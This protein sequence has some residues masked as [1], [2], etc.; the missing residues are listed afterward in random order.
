MQ[1]VNQLQLHIWIS[2]VA[3]EIPRV[4]L[5]ATPGP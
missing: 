1:E 3:V 4:S 2:D 5:L